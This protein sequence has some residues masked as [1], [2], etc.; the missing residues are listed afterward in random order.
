MEKGMTKFSPGM[1]QKVDAAVGHVLDQAEESRLPSLSANGRKIGRASKLVGLGLAVAGV[2]SGCLPGWVGDGGKSSPSLIPSGIVE[3]SNLPTGTPEI[4]IT[5]SATPTES[6]GNGGATGTPTPT[7]E[8][9]PS[10][11]P[12][13]EATPIPIEKVPTSETAK[14]FGNLHLFPFG[15]APGYFLNEQSP[16]VIAKIRDGDSLLIATI[17]GDK[18]GKLQKIAAGTSS[19]N[20]KDVHLYNYKNL[21]I[22]YK[23]S[24]NTVLRESYL[25]SD[26]STQLGVGIDIID[27]ALSVGED[28]T[29]I[30]TSVTPTGPNLI[31]SAQVK[32]NITT[33]T[34][35]NRCVGQ[36]VSGLYA[37]KFILFPGIITLLPKSN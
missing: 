16:Q 20:G 24:P 22:W 34:Q 14:R 6:L 15:T 17:I 26:T 1:E 30:N 4:S 13:P 33:F 28:L 12:T 35:I 7:V 21:I 37:E 32:Q 25:G 8:A 27:K 9:T 5:P 23:I 29:S 10:P 19:F 18:N 3:P 31:T 2:V 11:T 36:P